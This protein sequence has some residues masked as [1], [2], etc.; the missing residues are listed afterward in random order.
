M[1]S[2]SSSKVFARWRWDRSASLDIFELSIRRLDGRRGSL[3]AMMVV[4]M[5]MV[6]V[7]MSMSLGTLPADRCVP[8]GAI[9]ITFTVVVF[10]L[11]PFSS[12]SLDRRVHK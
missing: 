4:M 1:V 2:E 6:M 12:R 7:V 5:M 8:A 10:S 11:S 3:R 9:L